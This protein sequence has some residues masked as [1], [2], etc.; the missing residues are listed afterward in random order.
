MARSGLV[1]P[2]SGDYQRAAD[3]VQRFQDQA[4]SL[5]DAVLAVLAETLDLPV[6]TFDH[7]FDVMRVAVWR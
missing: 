5:F 6:W 2:S 7:Q 1:N 4:I 3:R